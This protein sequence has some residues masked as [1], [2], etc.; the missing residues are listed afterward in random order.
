MIKA[1]HIIHHSPLSPKP[2]TWILVH[3][4]NHHNKCCI[5]LA[6][7]I[8][9]FFSHQKYYRRNCTSFVIPVNGPRASDKVRDNTLTPC[10]NDRRGLQLVSSALD[11][12][13][14]HAHVPSA[15]LLAKKLLMSGPRLR[16]RSTGARPPTALQSVQAKLCV[17]QGSL[18]L[19]AQS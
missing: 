13:A 2:S 8:K 6:N 10:T 5:R 18:L 16:G 4:D 19:V 9:S 11:E 14:Q 3:H 1:A 12:G 7:A 15:V 17:L